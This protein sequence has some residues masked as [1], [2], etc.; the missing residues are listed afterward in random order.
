[1]E[2]GWFDINDF[3][4]PD[5]S[6]FI[7][8]IEELNT[9]ILVL[10]YM[11]KNFKYRYS[12]YAKSPYQLW[13]T[14]EG[15]CNDFA[16]FFVFMVNYQGID[17]WQIRIIFDDSNINHWLG[18]YKAENQILYTYTTNQYYGDDNEQPSF[19]EIVNTYCEYN[20]RIWK[21]YE[22]YNYDLDIIEEKTQP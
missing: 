6:Q 10:E 13:I 7:S 18:V 2:I 11:R 19:E 3:V 16:L 17:T 5:D 1:M 8:L 12:K 14:G 4:L 22:V 21:K 15:D 20:K 9:P